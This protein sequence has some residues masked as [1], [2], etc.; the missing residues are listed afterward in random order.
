MARFPEA[1][2]CTDVRRSPSR[3][4]GGC[5]S[6]PF[7][8]QQKCL[9]VSGR[10]SS[11]GGSWPVPSVSPRALAAAEQSDQQTREGDFFLQSGIP[12]PASSFSAGRKTPAQITYFDTTVCRIRFSLM[13][14]LPKRCNYQSVGRFMVGWMVRLL[15]VCFVKE[16]NVIRMK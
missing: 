1:P 6:G 12:V 9:R 14:F 10:V 5:A 11:S 2:W 8:S 3:G 13:L 15:A 16:L 7:G 4:D